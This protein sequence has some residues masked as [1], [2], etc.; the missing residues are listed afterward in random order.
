MLGLIG[1]KLGMTQVYGDDGVVV[2]V[3][4][5]EVLPNVVTALLT[6]DKNGY[7]AVQLGN[8]EQKE[9]RMTKPLVGKFKKIKLPTFYNIK[10]FRTDRAQDYKVG[11]KITIEHLEIGEKINIQGQ[12]K[13][14]GF[15]GVMKR[16]HFSGGND[17]HGNSVS[18]RVPGSIG[19]NTSP[20]R[21]IPGKRMPGHMGDE[22]VTVK[23]LE[24]VGK[25]VE[26]NLVLIKGAVPG[27]RSSKVVL[28]PHSM[29]F[30]NKILAGN[31][32]SKQEKA[33]DKKESSKEENKE[34]AA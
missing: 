8:Q 12:S 6:N 23:N 34:Q 19:Q 30:E 21:V 29:E 7:N 15:Q 25:E 28:Y 20:G 11:Q 26:Q 18:H 31:D 24:I 16:Y 3:T 33:V 1:K 17:S 22:T 9:S 4:I 5:V 32:K 2:P 13:G 14:K 10:E 27:S